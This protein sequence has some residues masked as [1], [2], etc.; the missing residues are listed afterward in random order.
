MALVVLAAV[1]A[2]FWWDEGVADLVIGL[3]AAWAGEER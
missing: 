3:G 2:A 1:A